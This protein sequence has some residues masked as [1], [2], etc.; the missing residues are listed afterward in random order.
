MLKHVDR[1]E[2]IGR[3]A[4]VFGMLHAAVHLEALRFEVCAEC[5]VRLDPVSE[6]HDSRECPEI[7][8]GAGTNVYDVLGVRGAR[9]N[10]EYLGD[11][12]THRRVMP[13]IEIG[14]HVR[15]DARIGVELSDLVRRLRT[16]GPP[17]VGKWERASTKSAGAALTSIA[18]YGLLVRLNLYELACCLG[19]R[20]ESR[21]R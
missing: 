20:E 16:T 4:A 18:K 7:V 8:A 17:F 1:Y 13:G 21:P 6:R 3:Y 5:V 14:A 15:A 12:L 2:Q 9:D 10:L 19:E 11:A